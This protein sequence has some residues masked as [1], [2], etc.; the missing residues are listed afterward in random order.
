MS[1]KKPPNHP[2]IHLNMNQLHN[3]LKHNHKKPQN[4]PLIIHLNMNEC[5]GPQKKQKKKKKIKVNQLHYEKGRIKS[6]Y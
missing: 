1:T 5:I 3:N 2:Q 6:K 4:H